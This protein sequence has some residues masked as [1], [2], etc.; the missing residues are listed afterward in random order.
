[1]TPIQTKFDCVLPFEDEIYDIIFTWRGAL[2]EVV[3]ISSD[4]QLKRGGHET[5]HIISTLTYQLF[6]NVRPLGPW[7][8]NFS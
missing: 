6:K 8:S 7:I 1:M 4:L 5:E 2:V 3:V